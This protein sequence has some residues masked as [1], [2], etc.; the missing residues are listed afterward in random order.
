MQ[1]SN[2]DIAFR[3]IILD[4]GG[5]ISVI[6]DDIVAQSLD[7]PEGRERDLFTQTHGATKFWFGCLY[8]AGHMKSWP[9]LVSHIRGWPDDVLYSSA[10]LIRLYSRSG[11]GPAED[12]L[13][14][15]VQVL[16]ALE[17]EVLWRKRGS[18][19]G[20]YSLE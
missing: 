5:L 14:W 13:F 12:R 10:E 6:Y 2:S 18:R 16:P 19:K 20:G 17:K 1:L 7:Y 4:Y 8:Q 11:Q 15:A 3:R 9:G